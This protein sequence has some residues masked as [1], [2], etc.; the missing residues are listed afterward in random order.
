VRDMYSGSVGSGYLLFA[1]LPD[2]E[3][4]EFDIFVGKSIDENGRKTDF[5]YTNVLFD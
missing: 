2:L 5:Y 1:I 4:S 3:G